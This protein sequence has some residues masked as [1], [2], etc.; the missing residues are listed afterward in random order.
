MDLST[1]GFLMRRGSPRAQDETQ[2]QGGC[3]WAERR[4]GHVR[5]QQ[6]WGSLGGCTS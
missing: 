6:L 3:R 4:A 5:A 1:E 2:W